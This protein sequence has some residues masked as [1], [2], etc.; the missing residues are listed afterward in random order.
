[1]GL[2]QW[3][4]LQIPE[5]KHLQENPFPPPSPT[6][7]TWP[8]TSYHNDIS[9]LMLQEPFQLPPGEHCAVALGPGVS[10]KGFD[11]PINVSQ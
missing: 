6:L 10:P 4:P 2:D 9:K 7:P 3:L 8:G 11:D 5:A 1:M